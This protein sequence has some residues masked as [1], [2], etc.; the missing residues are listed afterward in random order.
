MSIMK[1]EDYYSQELHW[2][3]VYRDQKMYEQ[4][5]EFLK[6]EW[7]ENNYDDVRSAFEMDLID[8]W[9]APHLVDEIDDWRQEFV[10]SEFNIYLENKWT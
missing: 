6:S 4:E 5:Y 1:N 3:D 7:L 10:N 8:H 9:Y 2:Y